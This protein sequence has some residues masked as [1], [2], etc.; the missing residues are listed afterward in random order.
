MNSSYKS[1]DSCNVMNT[2]NEN[3]EPAKKA[4]KVCLLLD[5]EKPARIGTSYQK[6]EGLQTTSNNK[7]R[8]PSPQLREAQQKLT[9]K[10]CLSERATSSFKISKETIEG[11]C[12]D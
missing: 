10:E 11:W 1:I 7:F 2:T 5:C 4:S 3:D 6:K 8:L 12:D 9:G